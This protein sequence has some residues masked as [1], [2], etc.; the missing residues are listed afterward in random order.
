LS[1]RRSS[2]AA[3]RL[4]VNGRFLK[5]TPTGLHRV[6]RS[7]LVGLREQGVPLEV[8]T[9]G[10][11]D[12]P[13]ADRAVAAPPGRAGD[14]LWEQLVLPVVAGRS[15]TLSLTNTAPVV[16]RNGAVLVHD[17]AWRVNP[18]WFRREARPY[19]AISLAAARRSRV[20][21][22]VSSQVAGELEEAGVDGHRITV[23]R[24]ALDESFAPVTDDDVARVRT[25]YGLDRP[26]VLH[27][28]WADPRK[29]AALAVRAHLAAAAVVPH[30]LVL[31]G[32][33]HRNFA[34]VELPDAP[35]VRKVGYVPDGDL[36]AL[37]TGAAAFLFPSQYEGFGLPPLEAVAC[38][39]PA[40]VSDIPVL[41]ESTAGAA[42][43]VAAGDVDA[44]AEAVIAAL[45]GTVEPGPLPQWTRADAATVL[46]RGL[47]PLWANGTDC[48]PCDYG[49][50]PSP[51][52]SPRR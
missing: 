47:S 39:T 19:G 52:S 11:V 10:P 38:G 3:R 31:T 1:D 15:P 23:V 50:S 24:P 7:L 36:R 16:R 26:F 51:P 25:E 49:R 4:V 20:V 8:V 43:T 40:L 28:G 17:L 30:D 29:D 5:A 41:R 2:D 13:L 32:L 45:T 44:W 42:T 14:H 48:P 22:T 27:V 9:P 34:A 37:M 18:Q 35:T 21:L 12:D 46:R 6:A 33:A